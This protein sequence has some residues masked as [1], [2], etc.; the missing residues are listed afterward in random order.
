MHASATKR[1][2]ST[3]EHR[4][5]KLYCG[6]LS[7]KVTLPMRGVPAPLRDR[8]I[9]SIPQQARC[10]PAR[11]TRHWH[12]CC[13]LLPEPPAP[14]HVSH[15]AKSKRFSKWLLR[16]ASCPSLL[17]VRKSRSDGGSGRRTARRPA[18]ASARGRARGR[19][20]PPA[21]G[22][23]LPQE[24]VCSPRAS[25][26]PGVDRFVRGQL[27]CPRSCRRPRRRAGAGGRGCPRTSPS[28]RGR[29]PRG[30]WS[31]CRGRRW[32]WSRGGASAFPRQR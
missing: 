2:D 7:P 22:P 15:H 1:R 20:E 29:W 5:D 32:G 9:I 12:C 30:R 3:L 18:H 23:C 27:T 11:A 17:P 24:P 16:P 14:P 26:R 28:S 21:L 31:P 13:S 25:R 10:R 8:F 4:T 6:R 19:P